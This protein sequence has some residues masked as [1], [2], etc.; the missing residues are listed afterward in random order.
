MAL[1]YAVPTMYQYREFALVG[2]LVS[3]GVDLIDTYRQ[4]GIY[5]ARVLKG[6]KPA[7]FLS[8]PCVAVFAHSPCNRAHDWELDRVQIL[9]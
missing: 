1:Q 6:A 9:K 4:H 7:E 2:G 8:L 5:I 3:Y